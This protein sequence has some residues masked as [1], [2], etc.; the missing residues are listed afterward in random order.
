METNTLREGQVWEYHNRPGE[1]GST[2]T[3]LKIETY[4]KSDRIIH[5]RVDGLSMQNPNAPN[6][7]SN[8]IGHL[9]FSEAAIVQSV[10]KLV[11]EQDSLPDFSE[12]Y[13][14]WRAAWNSGKG[15]YWTI[16]LKEAIAGIESVM[17]QRK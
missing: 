1:D 4:E 16:E 11:G 5:V 7:S 2:V 14:Q 6:G 9:P 12:G 10:N 17:N 13:Q 8:F 15:G 3:V